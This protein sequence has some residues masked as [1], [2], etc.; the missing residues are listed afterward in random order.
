MNRRQ[1]ANAIATRLTGVT[2]AVGYYGQIGQA[3]PGQTP[4][5]DPPLKTDGSGQVAPYFVFYPGALGDH[6]DAA[7]CR[8]D[9]P[10]EGGFQ[11]TAAAGHVEDLM[12]LV[13]RIDALLHQWHAEMQTMTKRRPGYE[14][15]QLIDENVTPKR[16]YA[17]LQYQATTT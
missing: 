12:A 17:P 16:P 14:V 6:P 15:P 7:V 1:L 13:D 2:N 10:R 5:K 3:L 9:D 4:P 8:S 11:I